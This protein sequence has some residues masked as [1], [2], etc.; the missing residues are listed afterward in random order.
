V[1]DTWLKSSNTGAAAAGCWLCTI[2]LMY[3]TLCALKWIAKKRVGRREG[4][5]VGLSDG[6]IVGEEV[7]CMIEQMPLNISC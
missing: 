6:L 4:S 2:L 7:C 3:I 1:V 5:F